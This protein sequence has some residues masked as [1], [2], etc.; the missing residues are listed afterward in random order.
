MLLVDAQDIWFQVPPEVLEERYRDILA[1]A[2]ARLVTHY[3][4][5]TMREVKERNLVDL[6]SS[7]VVFAAVKHCVPNQ[8]HTMACYA[9]PESPLPQD[10]YGGNTDSGIGFNEYSSNRQRF[11]NTGY[12][13]G[14]VGDM[15]RLFRRAGVMVEGKRRLLLAA[16][17]NRNAWDKMDDTSY[18]S[19]YWYHGSDQSI[20]AK[21]FGRQSYV[22]EVLRR[23]WDEDAGEEKDKQKSTFVNGVFVDDILNP[24][25]PHE[26]WWMD[27]MWA[28][29]ERFLELQEHLDVWIAG[30]RQLLERY[31]FGITLDYF[32]DLGHQTIDSE[33]DAQWLVHGDMPLTGQI[34]AESRSPFDCPLQLPGSSSTSSGLP[35]NLAHSP[36]PSHLDPEQDPEH[37]HSHWLDTPV[38]THLCLS[39]P[40]EAKLPAMIHHDGDKSQRASAWHHMSWL[41]EAAK[42]LLLRHAHDEYETPDVGAGDRDDVD[43]LAR[44]AEDRQGPR[45]GGAWIDKGFSKSWGQLCPRKMVVQGEVFGKDDARTA[46]R[47]GYDSG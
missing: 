41:Y 12:V 40:D 2:D 29:T 45:M 15:R 20:F 36:H 39:T 10:L 47:D 19:S 22:R 26:E 31:D 32:S 6:L 30:G 33:R 17:E 18:S 11:L 9:V 27:R 35:D 42:P 5:R 13:M 34:D 38:Y 7:R 1:Q 46:Q 23:K 37:A 16:G 25:F 21:I 43:G 28:P 14:P 24:S 4:R 3:G 44:V 8:P